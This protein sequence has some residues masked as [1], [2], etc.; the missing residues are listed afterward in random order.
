MLAGFAS[1]FFALC[2]LPRCEG[3]DV[4]SMGGQG[5]KEKGRL[6]SGAVHLRDEMELCGVGLIFCRSPD[7][8]VIS[9]QPG[10]LCH[11]QR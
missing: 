7:G 4:G 10:Q 1:L 8:T 3:A 6:V 9:S 11:I 2:L 5:S